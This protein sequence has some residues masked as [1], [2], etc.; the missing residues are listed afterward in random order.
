MPPPLYAHFALTPDAN[1]MP[2]DQQSLRCPHHLTYRHQLRITERW[3][4]D[5]S[6]FCTSLIQGLLDYRPLSWQKGV[7]LIDLEIAS[8]WRRQLRATQLRRDN[9]LVERMIQ[10]RLDLIAHLARDIWQREIAFI[11]PEDSPLCLYRAPMLYCTRTKGVLSLPD[12]ALYRYE[13]KR[14]SLIPLVTN[15]VYDKSLPSGFFAATQLHTDAIAR[16]L[17]ELNS[18]LDWS[19]GLSRGVV[20]WSEDKTTSDQTAFL[21]WVK[22]L[23]TVLTSLE[24]ESAPYSLTERPS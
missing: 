15:R 4:G 6:T 3:E 20:C 9:A 16:T 2:A 17:H 23:N 11:G 7:S 13:P 14:E 10:E 24:A 8:S 12:S 22:D 18:A 1:I 21:D 19:P 5:T